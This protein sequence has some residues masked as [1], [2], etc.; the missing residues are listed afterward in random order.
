MKVET[1]EVEEEGPEG[2]SSD[3]GE[4]DETEVGEE[5][6]EGKE[7][8][9]GEGEDSDGDVEMK[10]ADGKEGGDTDWVDED[11]ASATQHDDGDDIDQSAL[12]PP[13]SPES[14]SKTVPPWVY[15]S[16]VR[17]RGTTQGVGLDGFPIPLRYTE[18]LDFDDLGPDGHANLE[19][20]DANI[21]SLCAE[22]NVRY[23]QLI[24]LNDCAAAVRRK[25]TGSEMRP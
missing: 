6:D 13:G 18:T 19:A 8:G 7:V 20:L 22:M 10:G 25:L 24:F 2:S 4:K 21:R 15:W 12:S 5:E 11:A 23:T 16:P 14:K 1:P 3:E 9:D 17:F